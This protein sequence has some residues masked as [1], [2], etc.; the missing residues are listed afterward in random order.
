AEYPKPDLLAALGETCAPEIRAAVEAD[1]DLAGE[2]TEPR[3]FP[4]EELRAKEAELG[5]SHYRLQFLLDPRLADMDR[6]PLRLSDLVVMNLD[7]ELAPERVTYGGRA[8]DIPCLGFSGD[9]YLSPSHVA[10]RWLPYQGKILAVDPAGRGKDATTAYV[11]GQLNGY[12]FVLEKRRWVGEGYSDEVL[13]AM[14]E[15]GARHKVAVIVVEANFGDGMFTRLLEPHVHRSGHHCAIEEVK[16]AIQKE[17]R[18]T[19]T[20]EPIVQQHR[21]IIDPRVLE[22]DLGPIPG[23]PETAQL[24]YRLAYQFSRITREKGA[25]Q[26]DDE[27]DCLAIGAAW[28]K[29]AMAQDAR[30]QQGHEDDRR[31]LQEMEQFERHALNPWLAPKQ[32]A[33]GWM[34]QMTARPEQSGLRLPQPRRTGRGPRRASA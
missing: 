1:P 11:I 22:Q 25:L 26:H 24:P 13:A 6:Y 30:R 8:L 12:L 28:W 7:P 2:P 4:L 17:R 27:V 14:A 32:P 34:G 21:L 29:D 9:R 23:L 3:R 18:I 16:H 10:E 5:R 33:R 19:D 20:L 31:L 15:M